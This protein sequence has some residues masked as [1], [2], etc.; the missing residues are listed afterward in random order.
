MQVIDSSPS[1][2][3]AVA[4][5]RTR[6]GTVLRRSAPGDAGVLLSGLVTG[7]DD[8][9]SPER[10]NAFIRTGTTHLTAV[11]GSNLA[12]VA[13]ILATVG[14]ATIGRHR[15]SWQFVT[16]LGIWAYALRLRNPVAVAESRDRRDCRGRRV[17]RRQTARLRDLDPPGGWRDG[18]GGAATDRITR[19]S[20][21][22]RGLPR[23]GARPDRLDRRRIGLRG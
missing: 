4:D 2:Q 18:R 9:F 14:S 10:K 23:P 1:V 7:D 15:A 13:G 11:S 22:R 17:P 20:T 21:L 3:R 8:G 5:L 6:L 16:I 19:I 12:L